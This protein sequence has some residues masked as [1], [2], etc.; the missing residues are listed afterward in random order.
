MVVAAG[1]PGFADL[2]NR[3]GVTKFVPYV[4]GCITYQ[5][6]DGTPHWTGLIYQIAVRDPAGKILGVDFSLPN[7]KRPA[8]QI[9]T[10]QADSGS[11]PAN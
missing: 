10:L 7:G 5:E 3:F 9:V 8:E 2:H 11:G 1:D 6:S 4:V